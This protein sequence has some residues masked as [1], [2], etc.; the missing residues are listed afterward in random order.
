MGWTSFPISP[1]LQVPDRYKNAHAGLIII[2]IIVMAI[3]TGVVLVEVSIR[4]TVNFGGG[5]PWRREAWWRRI[6]LGRRRW[7]V[8]EVSRRRVG[9]REE[10]EVDEAGDEEADEE[11]VGRDQA[12]DGTGAPPGGSGPRGLTLGLNMHIRKCESE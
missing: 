9:F 7:R 4:I 8:V 12:E 1:P 11:D 5:G 2:L 10:L 3:V 6:S